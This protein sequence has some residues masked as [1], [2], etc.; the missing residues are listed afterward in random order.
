VTRIL[1]TNDDGVHA[2]GLRVARAILARIGRV[3]VF[4]PDREMSGASHA[5]TLNHPLRVTALGDD[6]YAVNGTPTDCVNLALNRLLEERPDLVFSGINRGNNVGFDISYSGT[7]AGAMEG[8]LHGVPAVAVSVA[9]A[10]ALAGPGV[11]TVVDSLVRR[12]LA[13]G[14]RPRLLNVNLPAGEIRGMRL[15]VQ[16]QVGFRSEV[17]EKV[18]PRGNRYYWIGGSHQHGEDRRR[19]SDVRTLEEGWVSVTPLALDATDHAEL[20]AMASGWADGSGER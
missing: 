7:V 3:V 19:N 12:L 8:A 1:L 17:V 20:E 18:D 9:A 13:A 16:G 14:G 11:D 6:T 2:E 10:A 4:A 5:L 15:T